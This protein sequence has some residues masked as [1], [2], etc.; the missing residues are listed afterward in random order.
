MRNG[1]MMRAESSGTVGVGIG[2]SEDRGLG[3]GVGVGVGDVEAISPIVIVSVLLHP[4][5]E[6]KAIAG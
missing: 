2:V 5:A 1:V 3:E 4:L 6:S